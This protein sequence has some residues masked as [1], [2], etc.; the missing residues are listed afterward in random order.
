ML[1]LNVG[2][3]PNAFLDD[4]GVLMIPVELEP[5]V[6]SALPESA[7][8]KRWGI[9]EDDRA[10]A[11]WVEYWL[12]VPTPETD[13]SKRVHRSVHVFTKKSLE[14]GATEGSING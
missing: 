1:P 11:Q 14:L 6:I 3:P 5:G 9:D 13:L 2:A 4:Q 8:Y 7:L 12:E 10:Q